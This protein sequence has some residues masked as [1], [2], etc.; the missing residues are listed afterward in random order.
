MSDWSQ[1][2]K[3]TST[4]SSTGVVGYVHEEDESSF[5]LVLRKI[6]N[7]QKRWKAIPKKKLNV[8]TTGQTTLKKTQKKTIQKKTTNVKKDK[9]NFLT[10]R[11]TT[12]KSDFKIQQ[13][14]TFQQLSKLKSK[15]PNVEDL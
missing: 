14:F 10:K 12:V 9:K 7:P 3:G 2:Q 11:S 1:K 6:Q 4:V 5:N 15:L 8:P 13:T